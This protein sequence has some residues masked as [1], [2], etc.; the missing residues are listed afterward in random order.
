MVTITLT[1]SEL[2]SIVLKHLNEQLGKLAP[3]EED[4]HFFVKSKQNWRSEWEQT[5][6][7]MSNRR[8]KYIPELKV[9]TG[10]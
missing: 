9:E 5:D 1:E 4:I 10:I 3:K 8:E 6:V 2:K 7:E